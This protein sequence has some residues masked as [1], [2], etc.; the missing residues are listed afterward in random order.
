M[1]RGS[2]QEH[3]MHEQEWRRQGHVHGLFSVSEK[4]VLNLV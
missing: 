2:E 1:S 4:G 3:K